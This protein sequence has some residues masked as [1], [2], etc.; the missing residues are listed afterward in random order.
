M[1]EIAEVAILKKFYKV[2]YICRY[3]SSLLIDFICRIFFIYFAAFGSDGDRAQ[4]WVQ[5]KNGYGGGI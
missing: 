1:A 4:H 5:A 3:R 2:Q